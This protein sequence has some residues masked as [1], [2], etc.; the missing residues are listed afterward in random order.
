MA[1][2]SCTGCAHA[3]YRIRVRRGTITMVKSWLTGC[4]YKVKIVWLGVIDSGFA[5]YL[6]I[7]GKIC[8]IGPGFDS[9]VAGNT[10]RRIGTNVYILAAAAEAAAAVNLS[11]SGCSSG[12]GAAIDACG[13]LPSPPD[14]H[15]TG[16][17]VGG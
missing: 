8:G 13:V 17:A 16:I 7:V 9:Q 11:C 15:I 6:S 3:V 12:N 10:Q 1:P 4:L 14:D 2:R 5:Q